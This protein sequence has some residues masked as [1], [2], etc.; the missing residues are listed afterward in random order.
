[1]NSEKLKI[2]RKDYYKKNKER[3]DKI[4]T[5]WQKENKDKR[6]E[7]MREYIK[8]YRLTDKQIKYRKNWWKTEKGKLC[9]SRNYHK[10]KEKGFIILIQNPFNELETIEWHHIDDSAYV[11]AIPRDLHKLY[12]G[13]YHKDN[14]MIIVN[15]IYG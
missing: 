15:Q 6:N 9:R 13:K 5:K 8:E 4:T 2:Y 11:V 14:M 3:L 12:C 7:Y 10:R 1:M